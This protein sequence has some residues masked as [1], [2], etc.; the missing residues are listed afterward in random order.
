MSSINNIGTKKNKLNTFKKY[1]NK[2]N[3]ELKKHI[4]SNFP[5][6]I[7]PMIN[8]MVDGG[9]RLRSI[10]SLIFG[11]IESIEDECLITDIAISIELIHCLSL[12]I[13][14]TPSMDNDDFR[15]EKPSFHKKFGLTKTN[16]TIYYLINKIT[17]LFSKYD[18]NTTNIIDVLN[19]NLNNLLEGQCLDINLDKVEIKKY[20]EE[21]YKKKRYLDTSSFISE[22]QVIFDI[23]PKDF[24][25]N[26]LDMFIKNIN[27]NFL[28]TSSLF[29]LA[30]LTPF[31]IH[32]SQIVLNNEELDED[33]LKEIK[34]FSNL[35]GI[36]FQYSDDILDIDQ[37]KLSNNPNVT[38]LIGVEQTINFIRNILAYL[39]SSLPSMLKKMN[40]YS[41]D[42]LQVVFEIF[43]IISDRCNKV[44]QLEV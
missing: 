41:S 9:K 44:L 40:V 27:L 15:R 4:S 36:A 35:F 39:K 42:K 38:F 21:Y 29:C 34:I 13:D 37:D 20:D 33:I 7:Q 43:T 1:Q 25:S 31:Y 18:F 11:N 22:Y 24:D 17:L 30:I 8:Y 32:H 5:T 28:K 10:L 6:C 16:L 3:L 2:V 14:D 19:C 26:K 23:L 12:V